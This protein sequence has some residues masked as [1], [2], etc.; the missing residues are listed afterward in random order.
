MISNMHVINKCNV[1]MSG[2]VTSLATRLIDYRLTFVPL[3]I[4]I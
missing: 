1:I 4:H 3:F 2:F